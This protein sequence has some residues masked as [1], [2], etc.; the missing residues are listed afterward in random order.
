VSSKSRYA[1]LAGALNRK[2]PE[3]QRKLA[4]SQDKDNYAQTTV[5]LA[6][7]MYGDLQKELTDGKLEY[8]QLVEDQLRDWLKRRRG[9][10]V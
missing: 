3:K 5:Y 9:G 4:K 10:D 1:R 6:R 7:D 2:S 8:S